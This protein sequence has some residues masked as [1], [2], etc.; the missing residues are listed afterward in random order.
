[1][2]PALREFFSWYFYV[3]GSMTTGRQ[4][5]NPAAGPALVLSVLP[6]TDESHR[7]SSKAFEK[8]TSFPPQADVGAGSGCV[9]SFLFFSFFFN[10]KPRDELASFSSQQLPVKVGQRA[11]LLCLHPPCKTG[12]YLLVATKCHN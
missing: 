7:W 4:H 9:C 10:R 2:V 3:A 6:N 11:W 5:Q 1:M 12:S 8:L